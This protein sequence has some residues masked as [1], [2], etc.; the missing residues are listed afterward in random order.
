MDLKLWPFDQQTCEIKVG[1]WTF[2]AY[3]L[4]L[5]VRKEGAIDTQYYHSLEWEIKSVAAKRNEKFY[6]CC[7]EPY[8]DISQRFNLKT[9]KL[10]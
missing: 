5:L 4:N 10:F 2:D 8:V 1:S 6:P 3:Q 7:P 9:F